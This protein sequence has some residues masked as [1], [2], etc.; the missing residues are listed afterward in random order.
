MMIIIHS[1]FVYGI[2]NSRNI[3]IIIIIIIIK[4]LILHRKK[5]ISTQKLP[6]NFTI[7]Y[8]EMSFNPSNIWRV[9]FLKH[10]PN[11]FIIFTTLKMA[12]L[13][14]ICIY[15]Y[16]YIMMHYIIL[17]FILLYLFNY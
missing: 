12:Y 1:K 6:V 2:N 11:S 16:N 4:L 14:F 17:L 10:T 7:D 9:I 8:Q 5:T 13:V 15:I 3:C